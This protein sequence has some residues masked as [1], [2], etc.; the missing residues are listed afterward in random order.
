MPLAAF[1]MPHGAVITIH[2]QTPIAVAHICL[3]LLATVTV[4]Y[5]AAVGIKWDGLICNM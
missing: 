4:H 2:N 5:G 3:M 1:G